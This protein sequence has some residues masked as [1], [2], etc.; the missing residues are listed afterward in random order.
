MAKRNPTTRKTWL[1]ILIFKFLEGLGCRIQC[2]YSTSGICRTK[3]T[4]SPAF[5]IST[6][7]LNLSLCGKVWHSFVVESECS[8]CLQIVFPPRLKTAWV[9]CSSHLSLPFLLQANRRLKIPM[10]FNNDAIL[11][12]LVN[13]IPGFLLQLRKKQ[14]KLFVVCASASRGCR[15][16]GCISCTP[17]L[18]SAAASVCF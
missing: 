16:R 8:G 2:F 15:Q 5:R 11:F 6:M 14:W 17:E 4:V 13:T 1:G 18:A 9:F 3:W 12:L 10:I 7:P